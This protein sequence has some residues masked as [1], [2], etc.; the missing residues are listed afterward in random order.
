MASNGVLRWV[1]VKSGNGSPRKP[2]IRSQKTETNNKSPK[3]TTR[4]PRN[5]SP[6]KKTTP[7]KSGNRSPK[8][9]K[10]KDECWM[11]Y[12][13]ND[14]GDEFAIKFHDTEQMANK[15]VQEMKKNPLLSG[16]KTTLAR[17]GKKM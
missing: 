3:P 7:K 1:R 6:K 2:R 16:Y 4:K 12:G 8:N 17:A 14:K 13:R 9:S 11:V 10:E 5:R 15:L